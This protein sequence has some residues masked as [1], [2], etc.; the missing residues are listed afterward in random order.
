MLHRPRAERVMWGGIM[1][2]VAIQLWREQAA[3]HT[4]GATGQP[5]LRLADA[6]DAAT[7]RRAAADG[8]ESGGEPLV[9]RKV[10]SR[11][12]C[13]YRFQRCGGGRRVIRRQGRGAY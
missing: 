1:T 2:M 12:L 6:M 10:A 11:R 9:T 3:E 13:G 8:D 4:T 7:R 5:Y